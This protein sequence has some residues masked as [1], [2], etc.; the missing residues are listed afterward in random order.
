[1]VSQKSREVLYFKIPVFLLDL[2]GYVLTLFLLLK[3]FPSI[4]LQGLA[5]SVINVEIYIV[6]AISFCISISLLGIRL[7]ERRINVSRIVWRAFLQTLCTYVVFI[8][9][10]AILYRT[11]PRR[12]LIYAFGLTLPSIIF[13]HLLANYGVRLIRKMGRNTRHV[14]II[15]ADENALALYR[16]LIMGQVMTGYKVKGFFS[17]LENPH[18]PEE[19]RYLGKVEDFFNWIQDNH[20]DEVYCSIPPSQHQ[21]LVNRIIQVCNNNFIEFYY[22]PTMDGYPHRDMAIHKFGKVSIIG[23]REEPLNTLWAQMIKRT[24]DIIISGLFLCTLYPFV[25]LFVW[26]CNLITGNRGPLYFRQQRTGYGG[27][28]FNIYKFRSMR[29]NAEADTVQATEDDPRKTK[30]GDFMRRTSI[31]E[32]P[33]FINVLLG[34]MSIVGPRPHMLLHTEIYNDLIDDYM[35]RHLAK[36]GITGWAQINGCRGETKTVEEMANRVEH[37]IWYIEHWTPLLDIVIILKTV[38]QVLPGHD[39]QAY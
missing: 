29:V 3:N 8:A 13:L 4:M 7:H 1:M 39:K 11:V 2:G 21:E 34:D 19:T 32:L 24:F 30:F 20:P 6:V 9:I 22:V 36:P 35:V 17:S 16:E 12:L 23:L 31:D 26:I 38:W 18:L 27:Q 5:P 15:G 37:D 28:N 10:F 25:V 33:Q 14:V